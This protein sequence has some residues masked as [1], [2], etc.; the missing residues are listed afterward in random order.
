MSQN[1]PPD[2]DI[3]AAAYIT[4]SI[5]IPRINNFCFLRQS[6]PN[7]LPDCGVIAAAY[8]VLSGEFSRAA[9]VVAAQPLLGA[10]AEIFRSIA[11]RYRV[12]GFQLFQIR[13]MVFIQQDQL[14]VGNQHLLRKPF[15]NFDAIHRAYVALSI[16]MPRIGNILACYGLPIRTAA[17]ADQHSQ[18]VTIGPLPD[19]GAICEAYATLTREI[20]LLSNLV[21]MPDQDENVNRQLIVTTRQ[22]RPGT[23]RESTQQPGQVP[24]GHRS[25]EFGDQKF[26]TDSAENDAIRARNRHTYVRDRNAMLQPLIDI[27]TGVKIPNCPTMADE[28]AK[29][30]E[31]AASCILE[32]LQIPPPRSLAAKRASVRRQLLGPA[33]P[34]GAA[35][36]DMAGDN[37]PVLL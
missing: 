17:A 1:N 3:V 28:I 22:H 35:G 29:L 26:E 10:L 36:K 37:Y 20:P 27:R 9:D 5:Q 18:P 4:L 13:S 15:P 21:M 11:T 8:M 32:A 30:S 14:G 6:E 12:V 16:H 23:R 7:D 33:M 24:G 34:G 31:R 19:I 2:F 25:A